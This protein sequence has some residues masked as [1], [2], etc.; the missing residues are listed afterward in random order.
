[1]TALGRGDR[2]EVDDAFARVDDAVGVA[3]RIDA[4]GVYANFSMMTRVADGTG[5]P[6]DEMTATMSTDLRAGLGVNELGSA[7]L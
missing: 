4:V 2:P 1:M 3:A 5:T 7:R 6:L